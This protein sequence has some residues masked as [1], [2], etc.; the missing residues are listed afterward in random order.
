MSSTAATDPYAA[1]KNLKQAGWFRNFDVSQDGRG[2]LRTPVADAPAL[3][4]SPA[5][6]LW[7]SHWT[8]PDG[9]SIFQRSNMDKSATTVIFDPMGNVLHEFQ[10]KNLVEAGDQILALNIV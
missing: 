8:K 4:G 1:Y 5:G 10:R 9:S 3:G 2:H 7:F 6:W